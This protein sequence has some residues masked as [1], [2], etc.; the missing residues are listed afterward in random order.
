MNDRLCIGILGTAQGPHVPALVKALT[1][2]GA[3]PA[4]LPPTR[5]TSCV[6]GRTTVA[7]AVWPTAIEN[8]DALLVRALPGGSLEQVI[9]RVDVLHRLEQAGLRV[10]NRP[11]TLEKTVDKFHTLALLAAAGLPVPRTVATE[12]FDQAMQAV[13]E[14]GAVVVKPLFGSLGAGMT[15]V[16][17]REVAYRVFRAL[18]LGRYVYYLQ[19]FLPHDNEDFRLFVLGGQVVAAMRRQGSGWKTNI[20]CGAVAQPYEPTPPLAALARQTAAV[21]GADYV[22][23]DILISDGRPYV[24]EANGVPG[25]N[26]LQSV[27][28][29]NIAD[30]VARYILEAARLARAAKSRVKGAGG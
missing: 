18:E 15:L 21:L 8:L 13:A 11:A 4:V 30:A 2:A 10:V 24:L 16:D 27:S 1:D 17:D 6:P 26:G 12:R 29:L 3:E 19:Q 25:W 20:A 23:V 14:M 5:I 7:G 9:Y 28:P 22:G